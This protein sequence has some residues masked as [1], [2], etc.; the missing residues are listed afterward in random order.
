MNNLTIRFDTTADDLALDRLA[1]LDSSVV[2]AAPR[3]LAEADGQLIAAIS[4]RDGR[5]IADPFTRS[6]DAV[7]LLRRR[8]R[9][10]DAP[11]RPRR[12]HAPSLALQ[13]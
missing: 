4:A 9:Q 8:A 3:L 7:A 12:L 6:A 5:A 11:A 10:L 13:R 1:Q 2:P